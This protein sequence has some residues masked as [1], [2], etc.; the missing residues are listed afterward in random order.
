MYF[1]YFLFMSIYT[2]AGDLMEIYRKHY[3]KVHKN[4][5]IIC[6]GKSNT[7]FKCGVIINRVIDLYKK[8]RLRKFL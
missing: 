5:A 4:S 3:T 2:N 6:Y 1:D 7:S 8:K